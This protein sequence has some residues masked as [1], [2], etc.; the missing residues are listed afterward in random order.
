MRT[1]L[2]CAPLIHKA[3]GTEKEGTVR[4][5]I[6]YLTREEEIEALLFAAAQIAAGLG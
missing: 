1:G 5:S 6:S 4:A 3:M 2:H